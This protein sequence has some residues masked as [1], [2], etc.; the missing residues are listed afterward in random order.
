MAEESG[1]CVGILGGEVARNT[2]TPLLSRIG[3]F[4]V[5]AMYSAVDD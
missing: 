2:H 1:I 3:F 5:A 4:Y